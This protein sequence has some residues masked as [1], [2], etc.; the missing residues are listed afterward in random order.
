MTS[1]TGQTVS[2]YKILERLGGGGMGVVYKAED[3]RL[4]RTVAVK[5][6]PPDLTRDADAKQRFIHEAQTASSLDHPN[7]CAIYEID[8]TSDGQLFMVMACYDG[9]SLK[10]KIERRPLEPQQAVNIAAQM[11]RGL[12]KA[13]R[14]GI[15][16]RDIKP[17]N[18][19]ITTEGIAKIVDFGLAKLAGQSGLTKTGW[20][21]GTAEYM[22]PE[23]VQGE[24]IDHRTDIWSFGVT[25]HQ[26]LTGTLP[27]ASEHQ[28]ALLYSIIHEA[29]ALH[30]L[31]GR[32]VPEHLALLI[33][34]CLEKDRSARPQNAEELLRSIESPLSRPGITLR[35][36]RTFRGRRRLLAVGLAAALLVAVA[37]RFIVFGPTTS[38]P[39]PAYVVIAEYGNATGQPVFDH[40]L[41]EALRVSLQQSRHFRVLPQSRVA[42]ARELLRIPERAALDGPAALSV[43]RREGARAVIAGSIASLGN[44]YDL[45]CTIL[46]ASDGEPIARL[47]ET[48]VRI[49]DVLGA[50][51]RLCEAVRAH[52]GE[53]LEQFSGTLQKLEE[54]TTSSLEALELYARAE[55]YSMQGKYGEAAALLEQAVRIDTMF[56]MAVS[57]L[58]YAYRKIGN[59]S[60]AVLYHAR[61]LPLANRVTE[62]ERYLMLE[63]YYGPSFEMDFP[64]AF[65]NIQQ[66]VIR[67]P[68]DASALSTLGHL[69]MFLGDTRTAL[70]ANARAAEL[71]SD[72]AGTS[73]NNS[74]YA[75][76][77][78]A[79]ADEALRFF[80]MSKTLRP[81][82]YGID[83]YMASTHLLKGDPDSCER[84]LRGALP[85]A[86]PFRA[87]QIRVLLA[88]LSYLLGK[89]AQAR[90]ECRQGIAALQQVRRIADQGYFHYLL[91]E[92]ALTEGNRPEYRS[93]LLKST[94]LAGSPYF[95]LALAGASFARNGYAR[96][97]RMTLDRLMAVRSRDPFFVN[98]R[99]AFVNLISGEIDRTAGRL[100]EARQHFESVERLRTGDPLY[101]M[102][103]K[104]LAQTLAGARDTSAVACYRSILARRGEAVMGS[105]SN[106]RC[107]GVWTASLWPEVHL[108]LG[109]L[110]SMVQRTPPSPLS[111]KKR[112]G[113]ERGEFLSRTD[114]VHKAATSEIDSALVWW[115]NAEES[116]RPAK[117]AQL[118]RSVADRIH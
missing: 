102:A 7:I 43:A 22:S 12:A 95:E 21:A 42:R 18:I 4:R 109:E 64:K 14:A 31:K 8:E 111:S 23:Q 24:A 11:A 110:L 26:M 48:A 88:S 25:F 103:Q 32:D 114:G 86:D 34:R 6:L 83:C 37:L 70:E 80:R 67:S 85:L 45:I 53:S 77:L 58:S 72:Y 87:A 91:G 99:S 51:D 78:D 81:D 27:F 60:L 113:S 39:S 20:T 106:F 49:E 89:P 9:E 2:H 59:D 52:L 84:I 56:A 35:A 3:T 40:S 69:A 82:Y 54:V 61:V 16:H 96:E 98:R 62:Q 75:L 57:E 71:S 105:L 50:M 104:G 66:A 55:T 19:M 108:E 76:A 65:E 15:T 30:A 10:Q 92:I 17:A 73:Y 38:P 33:E 115:R 46:N 100:R 28:P 1:L 93:E 68:D 47:R 117:R 63:L 79:R 74:G 36:R 5:F 118:L 97:A 13:H 29:P 112:G 101:W 116:F 94:S 90:I 107:G 44:T 41:T